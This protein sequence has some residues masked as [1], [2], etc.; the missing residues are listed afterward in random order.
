MCNPN[1]VYVFQISSWRSRG[2]LPDAID[3]TAT[4][5]EIQ[6]MDPFFRYSKLVPSLFQ[7]FIQFWS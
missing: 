3:V 2:S 6:H 1:T 5:V 4:I 7:Q